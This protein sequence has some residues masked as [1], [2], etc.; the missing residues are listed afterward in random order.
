[1]LEGDGCFVFVLGFIPLLTVLILLYYESP[2]VPV[3]GEL[4]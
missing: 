2:I 3:F 4:E 1:M